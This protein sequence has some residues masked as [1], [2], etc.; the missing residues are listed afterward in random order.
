MWSTTRRWSANRDPEGLNY[1]MTSLL[2]SSL[3]LSLSPSASPSLSLSHV[4]SVWLPKRGI[5][6]H[7]PLDV[8]SKS[9]P[10]DHGH[11]SQPVPPGRATREPM[12]R[13]FLF[14]PNERQMLRGRRRRRTARRAGGGGQ[15]MK[16]AEAR[17]AGSKK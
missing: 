11:Q 5:I 15:V 8:G 2:P 17:L 1:H 9:A 12:G 6:S 4:M 16:V 10:L 13:H 7:F 14:I 3:S